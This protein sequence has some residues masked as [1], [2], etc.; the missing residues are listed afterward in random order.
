MNATDAAQ[1]IVDR[2]V[3]RINNNIERLNRQSGLTTV[4][5]SRTVHTYHNKTRKDKYE[6]LMDGLHPGTCVL[7]QWEN[8]IDKHIRSQLEG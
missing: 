8:I 1:N 5:L 7:Q 6:L 3:W 4:W 2:G